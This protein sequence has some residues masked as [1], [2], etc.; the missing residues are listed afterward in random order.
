MEQTMNNRSTGKKA[1]LTFF[2]IV[3]L[4]S[5]VA[6]TMICRGGPEW[7]YLVLM[8]IPALAATAANCLSFREKGE[9]FSVKKLFAMGGFRKCKLRYVLLGCLLPLAYLLIPYM[10]YWRLY[11]ENYAYHGDPLVLVLKDILPVLVIG[12]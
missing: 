7:L 6:E 10:V 2:V 8:W 11:P 4:L 1:F 5:A 9:T 3:I 12:F